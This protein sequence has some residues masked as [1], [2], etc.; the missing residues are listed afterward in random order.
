MGKPRN[1]T[2]RYGT[3]RSAIIKPVRS[4]FRHISGEFF[5]ISQY[6]PRWLPPPSTLTHAQL[7]EAGNAKPPY[8]ED[9]PRKH[10]ERYGTWRNANI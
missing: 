6:S 1:H 3:R 7:G 9:T 2:E 5:R 8:T 10:T 4:K